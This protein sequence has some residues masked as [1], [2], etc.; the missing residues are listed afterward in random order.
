M[1]RPS[2]SPAVL[3]PADHA[4]TVAYH[5][6]ERVEVAVVQGT[7]SVGLA[8]AATS[9][10]VLVTRHAFAKAALGPSAPFPQEASFTRANNE[11]FS[12]FVVFLEA[13]AAVSLL[14]DAGF[15][16]NKL[17]SY[18][19]P[20]HLAGPDGGRGSHDRGRG[21]DRGGGKGGKGGKGGGE[22]SASVRVTARVSFGLRS[23]LDRW[24]NFRQSGPSSSVPLPL[25]PSSS[26]VMQVSIRFCSLGG[27]AA[28]ATTASGALALAKRVADGLWDEVLP[29]VVPGDDGSPPLWSVTG[30]PHG[31][32][33]GDGFSVSVALTLHESCTDA[34]IGRRLLCLP[35]FTCLPSLLQPLVLGQPLVD[36]VRADPVDVRLFFELPP[37]FERGARPVRIVHQGTPRELLHMGGFGAVEALRFR[38]GV[39]A[40]VTVID[41]T[42]GYRSP[43]LDFPSLAAAF[44]SQGAPSAVM[45]PPPPPFSMTAREVTEYCL[46]AA[47]QVAPTIEAAYEQAGVGLPKVDVSCRMCW[48]LAL[49]PGGAIPSSRAAL[50]TTRAGCTIAAGPEGLPLALGGALLTMPGDHCRECPREVG[51]SLA[52]HRGVH[53]VHPVVALRAVTAVPLAAR[54]GTVPVAPSLAA[55]GGGEPGAGSSADGATAPSS[56][57]TPADADFL[58][59]ISTGYELEDD[60]MGVAPASSGSVAPSCSLVS[61]SSIEPAAASSSAAVSVPVDG[62]GAPLVSPSVPLTRASPDRATSSDAGSGKRRAVTPGQSPGQPTRDGRALVS[63]HH[64]VLQ[65]GMGDRKYST[66]RCI[67]EVA[68]EH[69]ASPARTAPRSGTLNAV[70]PAIHALGQAVGR[71]SGGPPGRLFSMNEDGLHEF[72]LDGLSCS[73]AQVAELIGE[74]QWP[75]R[76]VSAIFEKLISGNVLA[77]SQPTAALEYDFIFFPANHPS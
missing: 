38:L 13:A 19:V 4:A 40:P 47:A 28:L 6:I 30:R 74:R 27:Y 17:I 75:A 26:R 72:S 21:G 73:A 68:R 77:L 44:P 33:R 64:S 15:V 58:H 56:G 12:F 36:D 65:A 49:F 70:L 11:P 63:T 3:S 35:S 41:S 9:R 52:V 67:W 45:P 42:H 14:G 7:G 50:D 62:A 1:Q 54:V 71:A 25:P 2:F 46:A 8:G 24:G 10:E 31:A 43:P 53:S 48:R 20:S 55:A 51:L 76:T 5:A 37:T 61:A 39:S 34:A 22:A 66:D 69:P 29:R 32:L 18:L 59:D 16:H 23:L 60:A 57:P